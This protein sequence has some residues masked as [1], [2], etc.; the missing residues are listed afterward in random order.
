LVERDGK[1]YAYRL[2]DKGNKVA[3]LIV[4]FHQRICGPL[5]NSLLHH[6]PDPAF[7]PDSKFETAL[8]KADDSIN[9]VIQLLK[10]A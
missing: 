3:L 7:K 1:R 6:R 4:L 10:A 2:T 8:H 9:N 5:A